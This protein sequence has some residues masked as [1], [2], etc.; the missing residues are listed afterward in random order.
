[1]SEDAPVRWWGAHEIPEDGTTVSVGPLVLR[2]HRDEREWR[3]AHRR[4]GPLEDDQCEVV[5]GAAFDDDQ[6]ERRVMVGRPGRTLELWPRL[7]DRAVVARPVKPLRLPAGERVDLYVGTPLFASLRVPEGVEL[8]EIALV[9]PHETWFGPSPVRGEL[10]YAARTRASVAIESLPKMMNR[11]T[12]RVTLINHAKDAMNVERI[13]LPVTRLRLGWNA[14]LER[15]VTDDVELE[16]ESD[17]ETA[18]VEIKEL[19]K[20]A[21]LLTPPRESMRSSW[22]HAL[23]AL[24]A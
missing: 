16:R 17:G 8:D 6:G 19:S 7:A 21:K 22:K 2:I 18:N 23:S 13:R 5:D 15:F 14:S 10:C 24:W 3:F 12:T 1:M 9:V 20:E 4:D 11:A